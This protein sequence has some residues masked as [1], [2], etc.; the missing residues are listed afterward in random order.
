M[1]KIYFLCGLP[2]SGNTLLGALINQNKNVSV[3]G[4]SITCDIL[5]E[6]YRLKFI[7]T[8][9]NFPDKK[10]LD[11][12]IKN[13]FNTYY[14]DWKSKYI[15]DRGPWGTPDN[16]K[17]LKEYFSDLKF[18]ILKRPILE[19][20]ASFIRIEQPQNI[21]QRCYDYLK[22]PHIIMREMWSIQNLIKEKQ[23]ICQVEYKDLIKDPKK[24]VKRIFDFLEIPFK[25]FKTENFEQF[26]ANEINYDDSVFNFKNSLHTIRTNKIEKNNYKLEDILSKE[27]IEKF[28]DLNL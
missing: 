22:G 18:I 23:N 3:T 20:M 2:R 28:K 21:E 11:G 26:K 15:I 10:S 8:Y 14:K 1:K 5:Y 4:N 27:I 24:E 9:K 16:L 13:I 6:V 12:F 17:I 25:D 7:K 19:C